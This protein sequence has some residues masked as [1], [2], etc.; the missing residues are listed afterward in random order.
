MQKRIVVCCDGT[1]NEP[2]QRAQKRAAPS[3]VVKM[4]MS[5]LPHDAEGRPQLVHYIKGVGTEG[6]W[7][8]F[9]G[10]A[11]GAGLSANVLEGYSFLVNNYEPG[12]R[13]Y[14]FGFSRGAYTARS[15]SGLINKC[16]ILKRDRLT[17]LA[18]AYR[19]YKQY[20]IKRDAPEAV[21]FRQTHG[22]EEE[23]PIEFLGVWDTV[24]ALGVPLPILFRLTR[25]RVRFHDTRLCAIVKHAYQA[26]ALDEKR[27]LFEATL[28]ETNRGPEEGVEQMWFVGVHSNVGGG[29][30]DSGLADIAFEWM[31]QKAEACGLALDPSGID[32]PVAPNEFG[33][34]VNSRKGF[35]RF[36]LPYHR[37]LFRSGTATQRLHASVVRRFAEDPTYRPINLI[38]AIGEDTPLGVCEREEDTRRLLA[39]VAPEKRGL[40][41]YFDRQ[42]AW[43][44]G[45]WV[46]AA[47]LFL[48]YGQHLARRLA[49]RFRAGGAGLFDGLVG[50]LA[51]IPGAF[52]KG[53]MG[54]FRV[55]FARPGR[56][57][58][59]A[60]ITLGL[61][62]ALMLEQCLRKGKNP[63]AAAAVSLLWFPLFYYLVLS[64]KN[65]F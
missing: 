6:L 64:V 14:L 40:R 11:F 46:L 2:S 50:F 48:Q 3:N 7:D 35:Y 44:V 26:L 13:L 30:A 18:E 16:G 52:W 59:F 32:P 54:F 8:R 65:V 29:Y 53:V 4:A 43:L 55:V 60:W 45:F 38:R 17:H 47:L 28:W 24:G 41:A 49:E 15:L 62:A 33:A 39:L 22:V 1:W 56:L 27:R 5:V 25:A 12:D 61:C 37:P 34:L 10:G 20:G 51:A 42:R 31:R 36:Y 19:F 57:D 23:T 9:T 58:T 63:V 21:R